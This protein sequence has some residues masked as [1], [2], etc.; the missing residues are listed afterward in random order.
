MMALLTIGD[1]E[2]MDSDHETDAGF[3]S[4]RVVV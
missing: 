1:G 3:R 4:E 2:D